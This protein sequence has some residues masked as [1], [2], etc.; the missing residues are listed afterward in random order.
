MGPLILGFFSIVN[1]TVLQDPQ[2][3]ESLGTKELQVQRADYK[4]YLDF[5]LHRGSVPLTPELFKV[6]CALICSIL[7]Y[8]ENRFIISILTP[9]GKI[10]LLKRI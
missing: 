7:Q 8:T 3:V 5:Q 1:T 6:N 2:L 4:L 10:N 9:L